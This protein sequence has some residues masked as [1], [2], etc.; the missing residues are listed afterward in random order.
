MFWHFTIQIWHQNRGE[1]FK[2]MKRFTE[3]LK[4]FRYFKNTL[5]FSRIYRE[6]KGNKMQIL[7]GLAK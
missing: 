2:V 4:F 5:E 7:Q 1:K 3:T 6:W